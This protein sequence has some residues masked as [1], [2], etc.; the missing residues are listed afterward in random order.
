MSGE[1]RLPG[2][3]KTIREDV[4]AMSDEEL[5]AGCSR[6]VAAGI[7]AGLNDWQVKFCQEIGKAWAMFGM[8]WKQRR[9]ARWI[10]IE[11]VTRLV[12]ASR[13]HE[14]LRKTNEEEL[15]S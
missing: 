14:W 12:R 7:D 4:Y 13:A 5:A 11:A 9:A 2:S 3:T 15:D 8:S 10:L 1:N 6:L